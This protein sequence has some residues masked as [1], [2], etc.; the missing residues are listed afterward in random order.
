MMNIGYNPTFDSKQRT[1]EVHILDFNKDIYG[2]E[3]RVEFVK[4]IRKEK[5]F[6][7]EQELKNTLKIDE[8]KIRNL[9]K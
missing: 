1:L 7:S 6:N 8:N 5:K 3:L 2:E 4:R 9:L